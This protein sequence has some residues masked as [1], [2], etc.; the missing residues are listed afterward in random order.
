[1]Y[2]GTVIKYR[3]ATHD[4][5]TPI[6]HK[7]SSKPVFH[8]GHTAQATMHTGPYCAH[9]QWSVESGNT[10]YGKKAGKLSTAVQVG[11]NTG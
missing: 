9:K 1:M 10:V 5:E 6:T 4:S 7:T 3:N 11:H 8:P 2:N